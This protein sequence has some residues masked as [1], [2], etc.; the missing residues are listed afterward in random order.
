MR[1]TDPIIEAEWGRELFGLGDP[2][3][4]QCVGVGREEEG[5]SSNRPE[6]AALVLAL[7]ATKTTYV[8]LYLCD[9]QVLLK[10]VQKWTG[11]GPKQTMVNA[12][13]ADIMILR[14]IIELLKARVATGAATFLV[15]VKAHRGEPLNEAADTLAEEARETAKEHREWSARTNRMVYQWEEEKGTR[16]S[17]WTGGVRKGAGQFVVKSIGKE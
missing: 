15:K 2:E 16:R 9:N 1:V 7:R 4:K 12:P 14:E 13:D 3:M 10:S 11:D 6:L 5:T 17:V 8:M